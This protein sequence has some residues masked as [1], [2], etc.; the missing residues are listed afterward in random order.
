[1]PDTLLSLN[2]IK[3]LINL[4]ETTKD[5]RYLSLENLGSELKNFKNLIFYI[6][7]MLLELAFYNFLTFFIT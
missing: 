4:Y 2:K 3:D 5:G 6:D 1:M 7:L